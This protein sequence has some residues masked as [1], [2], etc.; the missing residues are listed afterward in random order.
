[1]KQDGGGSRA[2]TGHSLYHAQRSDFHGAS[3]THHSMIEIPYIKDS[4]IGA[5]TQ[6]EPDF[7]ASACRLHN[8]DFCWM[9]SNADSAQP[10]PPA[11]GNHYDQLVPV[12]KPQTAWRVV[13]DEQ[14]PCLRASGA[15]R[16]GDFRV[17]AK[18]KDDFAE[19]SRKF[20][21][22]ISP[23]IDQQGSS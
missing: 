18:R 3:S 5:S 2:P 15:D 11:E 6:Q 16:F 12:L 14:R 21:P 10:N 22:Y 9:P 7:I 8:P 23:Q 13:L 19:L 4:Q 20:Q 17:H 1:M